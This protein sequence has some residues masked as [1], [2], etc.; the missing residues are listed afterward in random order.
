MKLTDNNALNVL[1]VVNVFALLAIFTLLWVL[2]KN[3]SVP[4]TT[5]KVAVN[6]ISESVQAGMVEKTQKTV[7]VKELSM[8][9]KINLEV[10]SAEKNLKDEI[11]KQV[12]SPKEL[13]EV[14]SLDELSDI[15][16]VVQYQKTKNEVQPKR[17]ISNADVTTVK[18]VKNAGKENVNKFNN[19]DVSGLKNRAEMFDTITARIASLMLDEKKSGGAALVEPNARNKYIDAIKSASVE[20]KNEMRTIIIKEGESLWEIAVR[21][22]GNGFLYTKIFE[23][24]PQLT[25]PD[26]IV[27]GDML[28]VPL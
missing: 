25:N 27:A 24:N 13:T 12:V 7:P 20:R 5:E 16:Y 6:N 21:A 2:W 18:I 14:K 28:R 22:Y 17:N 8:S 26:L 11:A 9:E 10:G 1:I 15:E 23:A 4:E 19:V 3:G